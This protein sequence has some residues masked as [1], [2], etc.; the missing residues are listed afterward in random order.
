LAPPNDLLVGQSLA[1]YT[2]RLLDPSR[3]A[4]VMRTLAAA[5]FP[6][7]G[8]LLVALAAAPLLCG[9]TEEALGR[10]AAARSAGVVALVAASYGAVYL[11]M[12]RPLAWQVG[13][14][15]ERLMLQLWP[16]ALFALFLALGSPEAKAAPNHLRVRQRARRR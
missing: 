10:R 5:L 6:F 12:P 11:L 2:E 15:I 9:R 14:S 8:P 4:I 3:Y 16:S 13:G 1:L 7:G